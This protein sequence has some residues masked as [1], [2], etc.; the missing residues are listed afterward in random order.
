MSSEPLQSRPTSNLVFTEANAADG[1]RFLADASARLAQSLDVLATVRTLSELAVESFADGCRITMLDEAAQSRGDYPFVHVALSSRSPEHEAL[2]REIQDRY[3]LAPD[4]PAGFPYVIRTGRSQLVPAEAFAAGA[5]AQLAQTPEQLAQLERQD[6]R[7]AMVVPLAA[8]GRT[9]GAITLVRHGPGE[10]PSFTER[11]L[12]IAEELGRRAGVAV[13]N[14][15][16]YTAELSARAGAQESEAQLADVLDSMIEAFYGYD[17]AWRFVRL[18]RAA[19]A[20]LR[21]AGLEP[22]DALGRTLWDVFPQTLGTEYERLMRRVMEERVP[23]QFTDRDLIHDRWLDVRVVPT[24]EGVAAYVQDVTERVVADQQ[25][26]LLLQVGALVGESLDAARTLDAIARAAVPQFADYTVVDVLDGEGTVRRMTGAHAD[27][28]QLPTLERVL[29]DPPL[30]DSHDIVAGVLRTG[31]PVLLTD[32]DAAT[33]DWPS[34]DPAFIA[35]VRALAPRSCIVVPLVAKGETLGSLLLARSRM[36]RAFTEEDLSVAL[37]IGRRAASALEHARL[38]EAERVARERA[39]REA[40]RVARLNRLTLAVAAADTRAEVTSVILQQA[41]SAASAVGGGVLEL[42]PDGRELVLLDVTG[43]GMEVRETYG[44]MS[45]ERAVPARDVLRNGD[46]VYLES[47][48]RWIAAGY[49]LPSPNPALRAGN[50]WAALPLRVDDRLLGVLTLAFADA[51]PIALSER[52]F[53]EAF[54]RQCAQA[55][56]RATL[57]ES[58]R[59]ARE[60]AEAASRA[61]GEFLAVMSHELRTPL[62]AIGGYVELLEM[63]IRGPVTPAQREDLERIQKSQRHLLLLINEV[64]NYARLESGAVTYELRPTVVAEVVAA[65]VPLVEPQ[66]AARMLTLSIEMPAASD[67]PAVVTADPDKLQQ[68]LLN[69]LSNAVKFTPAGGRVTVRCAAVADDAARLAIEVHDTGVGIPTDRH[70]AVFEPFV[71]VGRALNNPGEGTGL[72]LAISRD[73]AR[74][75][76]GELTVESAVGVGS[77]FRLALARG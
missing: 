48:E 39:E 68:I 75:M 17:P 49:E 12:H 19:R 16:L 66:R 63:G 74:G 71:Q 22:D 26:D 44:R 67:P 5:L 42:S 77:V 36:S 34:S 76:G 55:L 56:E 6:V 37:E 40:L 62:N 7:T 64:L 57:H 60:M 21:D 32:I 58:E 69:L 50:A 52:E 45:V 47:R 38:F 23:A 73:L 14:A 2:A 35:A 72:G 3:P 51:A 8:R 59:H 61:K 46:A 27:P 28:A 30:L 31:Q 10:R 41:V 54:A 18:N 11:D 70:D 25:R 9:L 65:T 20:R 1:E 33:I 53:L 15:R 13:D 24:A 29:A 43:Y 4:A